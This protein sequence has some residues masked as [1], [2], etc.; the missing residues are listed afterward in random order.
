L[1]RFPL[2][3]DDL[4]VMI[5]VTSSLRREHGA[6]IQAGDVVLVFRIAET[7]KSVV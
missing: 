4:P 1:K 2:V 7:V 5:R 6:R 3:S